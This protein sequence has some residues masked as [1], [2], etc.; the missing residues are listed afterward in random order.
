M[1]HV[2]AVVECN[3]VFK[4]GIWMC[5]SNGIL[6]VLVLGVPAEELLRAVHAIDLKSKSFYGIHVRGGSSGFH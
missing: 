6:I 4:S 5:P 2:V 1:G 3:F